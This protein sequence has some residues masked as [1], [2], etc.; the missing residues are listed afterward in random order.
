MDLSVLLGRACPITV[1]LT[2]SLRPR[3][4]GESLII[5]PASRRLPPWKSGSALRLRQRKLPRPVEDFRSRA[6]Q[7]HGVVPTLRDWQ[8]IVNPTVAAPELDVDRTVGA[9]LCGEVV[10]RIGMIGVRLEVAFAVVDR[11]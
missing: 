10:Q 7:A 5:A 2:G 4:E 6:E 3:G 8:A 11:D 9:F 1:S